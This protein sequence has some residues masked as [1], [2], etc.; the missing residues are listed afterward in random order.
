[1]KDK[2]QRI[3]ADSELL[4]LIKQSVKENLL[5]EKQ[6]N[7]FKLIFKFCFYFILSILFYVSIFWANHLTI[8]ILA[9][10][11]FGFSSLL[12]GFNFAHDFSH[13]A[14]FRNKKLNNLCYTLIYTLVGAHAESWKKRHI[15]SHHY[16]P[17]VKDYDADLQITS[18]IRVEP[19]TNY[20][21]FHQFQH[22]YASFAYTSYSLYWIFVKDYFIYFQDF[23]NKKLSFT[24][25]ISFWLQKIF[26]LSYLL[27]LPILYSNF[28]WFWVVI[29]FVV[30]HLFQSIFLLFTFFITHHVENTE[31][32]DT[33]SEGYIQ[34]SW[35]SNQI[36]SSN[37]F[38]PFSEFA[39][40]I[41]GGF[42]NHIAHHLFPHINHIYYP[43][44]NRILYQVL[45]EKG[46]EPNQTTFF[47][48]INS[49]LKHLKNMGQKEGFLRQ[50]S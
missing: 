50:A 45:L 19:S 46:F 13:D 6:K 16:A 25:H 10:I 47:S 3:Q 33:D 49:H 21:W 30:M 14:V 37:D 38:Y 4:R 12:L 40:F 39:N 9:Y 2:H 11:F 8:L 36:R 15:Q 28:A 41:F 29:A 17:N 26:Y 35:L 42:N 34:T 24:Y 7:A 18:L 31:Y 44:L 48:G 22:I 23:Y 20:R 27:F 43:Q 1:M 5:I 32:F